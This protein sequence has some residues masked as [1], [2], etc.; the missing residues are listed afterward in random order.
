MLA[1]AQLARII[2]K[3][4][5]HNADACVGMALLLGLLVA[6]WA[7]VVVHE[8]DKTAPDVGS[9]AAFIF[10]FMYATVFLTTLVIER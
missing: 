7:S 4:W 5:R 1:T 9:L 6:A 2:R 8:F 10:F 3:H